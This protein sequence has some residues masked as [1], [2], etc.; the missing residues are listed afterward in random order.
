MSRRLGSELS[1]EKVPDAD[2]LMR[3]VPYKRQDRDAESDEFL[4]ILNTAF[5]LGEKDEG[6]LSLTW[7]E[8]YGPKS[9]TTYGIAA[10]RFRDSLP[11]Q[12][13]GAKSAFAIG[14]AGSIRAVS[15]QYGKAVR[16][17]HAPDGPNTGHVE[18]HRFTDDDLRLL[19]ALAIE[20]FA[21]HVL[22]AQLTLS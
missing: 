14:Q 21:E 17:V 22:V 6:G 11:T 8:H 9:A 2:H 15:M 20:V 19:D 1:D 5:R 7:V 12:K 13:I 16:F 4:G 3:F 18:L 10:S